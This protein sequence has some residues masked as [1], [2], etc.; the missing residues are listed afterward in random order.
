MVCICTRSG[1]G[2]PDVCSS[3]APQLCLHKH[4]AGDATKKASSMYKQNLFSK[5]LEGGQECS[6]RTQC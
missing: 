4:L 6:V 3:G 1:I 2:H 5:G